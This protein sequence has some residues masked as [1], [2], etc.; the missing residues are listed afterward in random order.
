[1]VG[2]DQSIDVM[3][4]QNVFRVPA[5]RFHFLNDV[6]EAVIEYMVAGNSANIAQ[7]RNGYG[8]YT[9][10]HL[11][12][13]GSQQRY[14]AQTVWFEGDSDHDSF[15]N[16]GVPAIGFE[17][18]EYGVLALLPSVR[19][20]ADGRHAPEGKDAVASHRRGPRFTRP[21]SL[22]TSRSCGRSPGA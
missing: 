10:P 17:L 18:Q 15:L 3:R 1:M 14:N 9:R 7:F 20:C 11:A 19:G 8:L 21:S 22:P 4:T 5:S 2:A 16:A 6:A 13:N 12:H